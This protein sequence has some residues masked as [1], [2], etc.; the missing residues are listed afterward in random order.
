MPRD[1]LRAGVTT[2]GADNPSHRSQ[3]CPNA[4][5][6]SVYGIWARKDSKAVFNREELDIIHQSR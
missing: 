2:A 1:A 4:A 3:L 5:S 6:G